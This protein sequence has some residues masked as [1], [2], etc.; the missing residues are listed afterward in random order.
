MK[1]NENYESNKSVSVWRKA[2]NFFIFNLSNLK[3]NF[4]IFLPVLLF[5]V[6]FFFYY[7]FFPPTKFPLNKILEINSGMTIKE[8][9]IYLRENYVIRS[10][11]LFRFLVVWSRGNKGVVAGRYVFDL[12]PSIFDVV[13]KMTNTEFGMNVVKVT[14][15]EGLT[16]RGVAKI[17]A[18]EF[19]NF[20]SS[21]FLLLA[22]NRE[23]YL[24]PDTYFFDKEI[25]PERVLEAMNSNFYKRIEEINSDILSSGKE[26]SEIITMASILEGEARTEKTRK[27]ISDILWR[28]IDVGMP[29]QVDVSFVYLMGKGSAEVSL[30]DIDVDSPYNTYK[31]KGLPPAPISNPGLDSILAAIY[32]T[33]NKYWFF[34]SDKGGNMHYAVT[35]EEHKENKFKYLR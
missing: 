12:P 26:L 4:I 20:D 2:G 10:P 22:E 33:P 24:F 17:L 34:L 14:I 23:G 3:E 28:R 15:P 9:S 30:R 16:N 29:L 5:F 21:K 1:N 35:F 19:L 27:I 25:T 31:Y 18:K 13:S 8:A 6:V 7:L 11:L 32:P